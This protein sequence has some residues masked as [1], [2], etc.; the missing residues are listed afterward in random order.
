MTFCVNV[1]SNNKQ[2]QFTHH[3]K[4]EVVEWTNK[5]TMECARN[6]IHAQGLDLEIW[7]KVVNTMVYIKNRCPIRAL[8]LKTPQEAWTS[9]KLDIFHL[10]VFGC[11][12]CAHSH[13]HHTYAR[14]K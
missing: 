10:R 9:N 2:M 7:A 14:Y 13:M 1:E 12:T 11:K 4:M 6:M 5:T 3:N 8:N